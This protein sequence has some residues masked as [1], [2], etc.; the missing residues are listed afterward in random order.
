MID[1]PHVTH[2]A[3]AP[4]AFIHLVVPRAEIRTVMG[5][6]LAEIHAALAAQG[7]APAGPWFTHHRRVDPAVFDFEICSPVGSPIIPTGRVQAGCLPAATVAQTVLH[8]S[9]EELADAWGRLESW[10]TTQGHRPAADLWVRYVV[11]PE[12]SAN[13]ADWRT[14]LNWPLLGHP[15]RRA[16][17]RG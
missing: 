1:T 10:I 13:P 14:E 11:G 15:S 4:M 7:T 17:A 5:P 3:D 16:D 9:Y 6:G 12:S 2:T 8:G